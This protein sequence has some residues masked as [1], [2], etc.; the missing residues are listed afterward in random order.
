MLNL[1][2]HLKRY[3][4]WYIVGLSLVTL[5]IALPI[6][7]SLFNKE[8]LQGGRIA[9]AVGCFGLCVGLAS[10]LYYLL[11]KHDATKYLQ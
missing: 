9:L 11:Q 4:L 2:L 5:L 8:N 3:A 6:A 10:V 7:Q 1:S